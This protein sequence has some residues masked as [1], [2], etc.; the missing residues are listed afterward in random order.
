MNTVFPKL[1]LL[2]KNAL[3]V[4]Q[5]HHRPSRLHP[6]ATSVSCESLFSTAA[7][8]VHKIRSSLDPHTVNMLSFLWDWCSWHWTFKL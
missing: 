3:C 8:T 4:Y 6:V 2:T 5:L 7:Y 1:A